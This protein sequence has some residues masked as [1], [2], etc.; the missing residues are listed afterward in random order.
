MLLSCLQALPLHEAT[1]NIPIGLG[2]PWM[3]KAKDLLLTLLPSGLTI[4]RRAAAEGLALLATLGVTE[5]AHFLQSSLLHSLDE[6]MQ[7]NKPD[8]KARTIALEPVSAARAGSLLTLACIQR[9]A[10]NVA[11]R[12]SA[13]ARGRVFG[14]ATDEAVAKGNEELPVLQMMTRILPSAACHGFKDYFAVKTHA[15]HS[16]AALLIYSSRMNAAVLGEDDKQLLRKGIELIEENFTASWTAATMDADKGHEAEK[17]SSENAFLAVL[18]RLMT[19]LLRFLDQI[20]D[21]SDTARRFAAMAAVILESSGSHPSVFVEGMAF[22]EILARNK[23]LIGEPSTRV[24]YS[25][26]PLFSWA[27][28]AMSALSPHASVVT[29]KDGKSLRAVV[30]LVRQLAS[31]HVSLSQWSEMKI[32]D[33]MF[34]SIDS[35]F[36]SRSCRGGG[37]LRTVATNREMERFFAQGNRLE[38]EMFETVHLLLALEKTSHDFDRSRLLQWLLMARHLLTPFS[39]Q[40]DAD[41][42]YNREQV[43]AA[44]KE[45]AI[46]HAAC[47]YGTTGSIRWPARCL[48]AQVAAEALGALVDNEREAFP[49]LR[50]SAQFDPALAEAACAE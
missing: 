4:V 16:F 44:A 2:P 11:K 50:K 5:D 40:A 47:S 13:R 27:P 14:S 17:I 28:I 19:F 38:R 42:V 10:H 21:D 32:V 12:K 39:S 35:E 43:A 1:H 49:D 31:Q 3:N 7:G 9:T 6:V 23:H 45:E 34:A 36:G 15:L 18:L 41:P 37:L 24:L 29:P 30:C 33:R 25:E 46:E 22:F 26:N 8:G 48:A 20:Q